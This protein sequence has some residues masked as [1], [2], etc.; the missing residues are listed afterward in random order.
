MTGTP[1]APISAQLERAGDAQDDP[2]HR[3][4]GERIPAERRPAGDLNVTLDCQLRHSS[5]FTLSV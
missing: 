2:G 5:Y 4:G 1:A 3:R